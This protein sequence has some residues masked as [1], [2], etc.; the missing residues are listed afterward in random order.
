MNGAV[1]TVYDG[2][3]EINFEIFSGNRTLLK[4]F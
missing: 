4:T 2:Q 3:T 1:E